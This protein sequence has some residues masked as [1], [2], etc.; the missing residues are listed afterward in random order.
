MTSRRS[1]CWRTSSNRRGIACGHLPNRF[2]RGRRL[3]QNQEF[4]RSS[5]MVF[6][7]RSM[8]RVPVLNVRYLFRKLV[9]EKENDRI[10]KLT[11]GLCCVIMAEIVS[12]AKLE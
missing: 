11:L 9:S 1:R 12:Q 5:L 2:Q 7:M 6:E 8:L 3:F 10:R 4:G